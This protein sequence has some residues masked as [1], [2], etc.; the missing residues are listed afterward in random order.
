MH[1]FGLRHRMA[2]LSLTSSHPGRTF[3][4]VRGHASPGRLAR[5]TVAASNGRSRL[6]PDENVVGSTHQY[7]GMT[8]EGETT[9]DAQSLLC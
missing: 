4:P 3:W 2:N 9:Y 5:A 6:D 1:D 8:G 7:A